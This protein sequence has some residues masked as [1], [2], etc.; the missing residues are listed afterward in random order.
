MIALGTIQG[1]SD[2]IRN[3]PTQKYGPIMPGDIKYKD[4]N[5]DG[6]VDDNELDLY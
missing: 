5:G 4:V 1:L 2:D 3:S 6:V